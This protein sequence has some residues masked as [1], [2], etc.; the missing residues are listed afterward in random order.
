MAD[1]TRQADAIEVTPEMTQEAV[2]LVGERQEENVVADEFIIIPE[3][4]EAGGSIAA[5]WD[6]DCPSLDASTHHDLARLLYLAM[7]PLE[8]PKEHQKPR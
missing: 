1:K 2:R 6:Y 4:L 7:R 5:A 8:P 3:M